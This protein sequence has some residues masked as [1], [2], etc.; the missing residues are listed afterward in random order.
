VGDTGPKLKWGGTDPAQSAGKYFSFGRVPPLF[1]SKSTIVVLV[2]AFVMVST[3]WSVSCLLFSYSRCPPCPAICKSGG[4]VPPHHCPTMIACWRCS[5]LAQLNWR[6]RC[7]EFYGR[8]RDLWLLSADGIG[9]SSRVT[10]FGNQ[11]CEPATGYIT[12][13]TAS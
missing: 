3:V 6:L 1:G 7:L 12:L 4:H 13:A 11:C 10:K 8:S 9:T 5:M 2:I